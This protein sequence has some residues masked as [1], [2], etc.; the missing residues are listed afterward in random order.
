MDVSGRSGW[1][2]WESVADAASLLGNHGSAQD[3][4]LG[5]MTTVPVAF[6]RVGDLGDFCIGAIRDESRG[7]AWGE[8][9]KKEERRGRSC[10]T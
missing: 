9:W 7:F 1:A 8:R 3:G 6:V 10:A 2:P 4:P 5:G